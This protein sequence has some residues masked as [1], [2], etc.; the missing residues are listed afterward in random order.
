MATS[1]S[2]TNE[3]RRVSISLFHWG[4]SL[5]AIIVLAVGFFCL[6]D[7]LP[8]PPGQQTVRAIVEPAEPELPAATK[9]AI[10]RDKF[11]LSNIPTSFAFSQDGGSLYVGAGLW[12]AKFRVWDVTNGKLVHEVSVEE[13]SRYFR[14]DNGSA[15]WS[16][17]PAID[18]STIAFG[19]TFTKRKWFATWDR[20]SGA[21][22]EI[23]ALPVPAFVA[24]GLRSGEFF[25]GSADGAISA[26]DISTQRMTPIGKMQ[27][28][29]VKLFVVPG[30]NALFAVADRGEVAAWKIPSGEP[31]ARAQVADSIAGFD[32]TR[33]GRRIAVNDKAGR[34]IIFG[35]DGH[36]FR[37]ESTREFDDPLMGAVWSHDAGLIAALI[38]AGRAGADNSAA[39]DDGGNDHGAGGKRRL[40]L[41]N[42]KTWTEVP[43]GLVDEEIVTALFS[44]VP[45]ILA[46][47]HTSG[48]PTVVDLRNGQIR[49]LDPIAN[50]IASIPDA[51]P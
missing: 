9:Q 36:E 22:A 26:V 39:G 1:D 38:P 8:R 49:R 47:V 50:E 4:W 32:V 3:S 23:P 5:P 20:G 6:L 42:T 46:V 37:L 14:A 17:A 48:R 13:K 51:T 43:T 30:E 33:D 29:P 28:G 25:C 27:S 18:D 10:E 44:P 19:G 24:A 11:N 15:V 12:N 45:G 35:F 40:R 41:W 2:V 21:L 31:I 7:R 16:I 34:L